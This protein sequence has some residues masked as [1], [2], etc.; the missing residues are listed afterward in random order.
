MFIHWR[1]LRCYT[2]LLDLKREN[3]KG[4]AM[5][6]EIGI[7]IFSVTVLDFGKASHSCQ[8]PML[9]PQGDPGSR[10]SP[11]KDV[12]WWESRHQE[13][14][15]FYYDWEASL[16]GNKHSN[17]RFCSNIFMKRKPLQTIYRSFG[18]SV[19]CVLIP[20]LLFPPVLTHICH[21]EPLFSKWLSVLCVC[22]CVHVN[23]YMQSWG[24]GCINA[25]VLLWACFS[26]GDFYPPCLP[27]SFLSSSSSC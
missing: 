24:C 23:A 8:A 13:P 21:Q 12:E 18:F 14:L 5:A 7:Y 22:A 17:S 9:L 19:W 2:H 3:N 27:P 6:R 20:L 4:E 16:W 25:L 26:Y 10:C 11:P 15:T 1:H